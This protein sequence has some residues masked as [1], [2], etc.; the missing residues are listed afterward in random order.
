MKG[1]RAGQVELPPAEHCRATRGSRCRHVL[2]L[3]CAALLLAGCGTGPSLVSRQPTVPAKYR[4]YFVVAATRCPAVLTPA[5]LAGQAYVESRFRADAVSNQNAQGLM[6]ITP[7]IWSRYGT[8]AN[9]DGRADPFTPADSIA[10][11]AKFNCSLA[12]GL[13]AVPGSRTELRLAA[14][15]AGINAVRQYQAV[16]PYPETRNYVQQV[17]SWAQ[18]LADE[19]PAQGSGTSA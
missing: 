4:P 14:Y 12:R 17:Q 13:R 1:G 5:G 8:D 6:Q 2:L 15:N 7:A 9:G 11:A 19:F 18:Q 16:P 3:L 10:T